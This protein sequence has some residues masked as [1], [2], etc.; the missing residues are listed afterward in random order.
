ML[1]LVER[2]KEMDIVRERQGIVR[3]RSVREPYGAAAL[4][5]AAGD[6]DLLS[7][8]AALQPSGCKVHFAKNSFEARA[9]LAADRIPVV[10]VDGDSEAL[11]WR[12]VLAQFSE[13]HAF[14]KPKFILISRLAD[15]RLWA[16]VL[17][18]GAYDLL[19]KPLVAD[20]LVWVVRSA[21]SEGN[22]L[23]SSAQPAGAMERSAWNRY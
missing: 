9:L 3:R 14:A 1:S 2:R 18:L 13:D 6:S 12:E 16:E 10:I 15:E 11:C 20:E 5:I 23:S 4:V 17:N 8:T 19:P 7:M 21:L 22:G